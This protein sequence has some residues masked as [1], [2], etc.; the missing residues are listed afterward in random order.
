MYSANGTPWWVQT[1]YGA[2]GHS[3]KIWS[4]TYRNE[5]IENWSVEY[6][7]YSLSNSANIDF[8]FWN[9]I[10]Y[11]TPSECTLSFFV[12]NNNGSTWESYSG[13]ETGEHNFTST[14]NQMLC[15]IQGSG[16]VA[17]NAYKMS[18]T[19]DSI[20]FGTKYA[21][22]MDVSIHNKMTR[23]KLKGKKI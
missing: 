5:L 11:F 21:A 18:D 15:K 17:K 19:K 10:D 16:T 9:R 3:F 8:V 13:T 6:G 22:E 2:D 4:D 7:S 1:G 23:F 14:G 20:T 12:S